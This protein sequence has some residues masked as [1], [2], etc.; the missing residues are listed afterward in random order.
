M[1]VSISGVSIEE[2]EEVRIMLVVG[3]ERA[4]S[5]VVSAVKEGVVGRKVIEGTCLPI[6]SLRGELKECG[7]R[8]EV[9][10]L[11]HLHARGE[12]KEW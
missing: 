7:L 12:C 8:R 6:L 4:T 5:V 2:D 3:R 11:I 9:E 10:C 1:R